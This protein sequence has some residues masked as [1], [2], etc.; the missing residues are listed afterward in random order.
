M[1]VLLQLN[2]AAPPADMADITSISQALTSLMRALGPA[3]SGF[4]WGLAV[5]SA[6]P[7]HQF[8]PFLTILAWGLVMQQ[9][10]TFVRRPS[11]VGL[12]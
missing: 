2:D 12:D 9:G 6:L 10:F 7:L 5:H 8:F 11:A 4:A 3:S 1:L